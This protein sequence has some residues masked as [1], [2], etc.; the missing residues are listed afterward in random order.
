MGPILVFR[1]IFLL[2]PLYKRGGGNQTLVWKVRSSLRLA[3]TFPYVYHGWSFICRSNVT[4]Y[5]YRE[6]SL[7]SPQRFKLRFIF[8]PAVTPAERW[9][10]K[11]IVTIKGNGRRQDSERFAWPG[12]TEILITFLTSTYI[13]HI[14]IYRLPSSKF[15]NFTTFYLHKNV[16]I[17]IWI[18]VFLCFIH[19]WDNVRLKLI[20]SKWEK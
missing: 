2:P 10:W 12:N 3:G 9:K 11:I 20:P 6:A 14:P 5:E 7:F 13:F 1:L 17:Y 19:V 16:N 4:C 15:G 18:R 8:M